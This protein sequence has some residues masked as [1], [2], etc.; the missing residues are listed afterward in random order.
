MKFRPSLGLLLTSLMMASCGSFGQPPASAAPASAAITTSSTAASSTAATAATQDFAT[1]LSAL[2]NE[3]L[4]SGISA[5]TVQSAFANVNAPL[6]RVLELDR[7]QPEFVQTFTAYMR[8]RMSDARIARGRALLQKHADLFARLEREYGVQPQYLVAFW[9][10][11][12]NFGDNTG[13]FSVVDALATLAYDPRRADFFRTELLTALRIIDA[14]HITANAMTGSWAGAM[15]QCQFMPSTFM[16]YAKDGDGD[17]RID[18][19]GSVPDVMTS[20]AN[21][22]SRS[23]WQRGERWG[24]EVIL[25]KGFD[26]TLADTNVRKSVTQWNTLGVRRA[27]G[28]PLG[29]SEQLGSIVVPAGAAGPAFLGYG[30]FQTTMVWNRSIFYAISVG[31]LADRFM[32]AGPL[33]HMPVNE[34]ALTRDDVIELQTRLNQLGFDTGTPDGVLGSRTRT[35]VREYQLRHA[36]AAD[37]YASAAFLASL[38]ETSPLTPA[39]GAQPR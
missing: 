13:G 18:L 26:F 38:R 22:L 2:R 20:A 15:G 10:L 23:G 21:Y 4:A 17:G 34:Q 24:R 7:S 30:N 28:T 1:W 6:P 8:N 35:A 16:S 14:G 36:L 9:A 3:A 33:L 5:N 37:G 12:S 31:H 25:P 29:A 39:A 32:G 19:W 27:D 11:E